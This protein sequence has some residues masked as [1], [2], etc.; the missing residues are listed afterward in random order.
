MEQIL[1]MI[2]DMQQSI[3]TSTVTI[4]EHIYRVQGASKWAVA[5]L[6]KSMVNCPRPWDR[7]GDSTAACHFLAAYANWALSQKEKMNSKGA[8]R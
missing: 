6:T 1:Q 8:F 2:V 3:A 4:A 5:K 7:K